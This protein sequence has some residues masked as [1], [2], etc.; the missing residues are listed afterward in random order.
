MYY[1]DSEL[2]RA[3]S[4][5]RRLFLSNEFT[6]PSGRH[7]TNSDLNCTLSNKIRINKLSI[8]DTDVYNPMGQNVALSKD[9]FANNVFNR[10][11][12]FGDFDFSEFKKIFELIAI[13][14]ESVRPQSVDGHSQS[15]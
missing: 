14:A 3:D 15:D 12:N 10:V 1:K 13:I 9:A 6:Y 4:A 2:M 11:E 7:K 5:G 8:I